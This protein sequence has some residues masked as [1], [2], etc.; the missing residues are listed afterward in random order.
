MHLPP[1]SSKRICPHCGSK[2]VQRTRRRG[3]YIRVVSLILNV[4]PF[5]C[6]SCDYLFLAPAYRVP[7]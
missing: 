3:L 6:E 1:V 7:K 5:R 2:S 4:R